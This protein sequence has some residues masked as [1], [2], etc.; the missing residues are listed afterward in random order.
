MTHALST[1]PV[2]TFQRFM[3]I[4]DT[5]P[6]FDLSLPFA[7]AWEYSNELLNKFNKNKTLA[8]LQALL[9]NV[10]LENLKSLNLEDVKYPL[11]GEWLCRKLVLGQN[12]T[13]KHKAK[14]IAHGK[15][16]LADYSTLGQ[17]S[18]LVTVSH[19]IHPSQRHLIKIDSINISQ[20]ALVGAKVTLLCTGKGKA[21]EIGKHSIMLPG[22][23]VTKDVEDYTVIYGLNKVLLSGKEYFKE[24]SSGNSLKDRLKPEALKVVREYVPQ[25]N[26]YEDLSLDFALDEKTYNFRYTHKLNDSLINR[27]EFFYNSSESSLN[28]SFLVPPLYFKGYIPKIYSKSILNSNTSFFSFDLS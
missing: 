4:A 26:I 22:S 23:V 27:S 21:L 20:F 18:L 28:S 2:K 3:D 11:D 6:L 10:G 15:I 14:L 5:L 1:D 9:P 7:L 17:G 16:K 24:I 19:P 12:V 25:Q 13:I 8:S